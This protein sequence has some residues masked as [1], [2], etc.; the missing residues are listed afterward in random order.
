MKMSEVIIN[1]L[2]EFVDDSVTTV[3]LNTTEKNKKVSKNNSPSRINNSPSRINNPQIGMIPESLQF[4]NFVQNKNNNSTVNNNMSIE[5]FTA[6]ESL[7]KA[8][9]RSKLTLSYLDILKLSF[10]KCNKEIKKKKHLLQLGQKEMYKYLDYL[11]IVKSLQDVSKIKVVI[12]SENQ[13]K[14]FDQIGKVQL[15]ERND[16]NIKGKHS[17]LIKDIV[18]TK[19]ELKEAWGAIQTDTDHYSQKIIDLIDEEIKAKLFE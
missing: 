4:N 2:F 12:F 9:Q 7:T 1:S 19:E 13:L 3:Q 5:Q 18:Y 15:R 10:C 17:I 6:T 14:I 8:K 11:D 16:E